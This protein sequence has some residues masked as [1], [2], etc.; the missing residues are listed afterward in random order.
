[1]IILIPGIPLPEKSQKECGLRM[2]Y[3]YGDLNLVI[4]LLSSGYGKLKF[5][6]LLNTND[7]IF[8]EN[9]SIYHSIITLVENPGRIVVRSWQ[10][11]TT[12]F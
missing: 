10:D 6:N 11:P 9:G 4:S 5:C 1:M 7:L 2:V 12:G 8:L 3:A